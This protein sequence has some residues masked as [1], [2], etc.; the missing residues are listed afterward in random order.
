MQSYKSISNDQNNNEIK[1]KI[2]FGLV[3][4]VRF[5]GDGFS[6]FIYF[7]GIHIFSRTFIRGVPSYR[8]LFF[9]KK[10]TPIQRTYRLVKDV[11]YFKR[12]EYKRIFVLF[13]N[14]GETRLALEHLKGKISDTC[15]IVYTKRYH[16]QLLEMILPDIDNMFYPEYFSVHLSNK[17]KEEYFIGNCRISLLGLI[18]YFKNYERLIQLSTDGC[19]RHFYFNYVSSILREKQ[20]INI[21]PLILQKES[22]NSAREKLNFLIG[23]NKFVII[24]NETFSNQNLSPEFYQELCRML[25]QQG[26]K[27][28]FN[29]TGINKSNSLGISSFLSIQELLEIASHAEFVIGIRSGILDVLASNCSHIVAIYTAFK[30]RPGFDSLSAEKVL[31]AFSLKKIP[32][33]NTPRIDEV[34]ISNNECI[35]QS[36]DKIFGALYG[37]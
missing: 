11:R 15:L 17:A 31:E 16:K 3:K 1:H 4:Y 14:L 24:C 36:L 13:N 8:F 22:I 19:V 33:Q 37:K 23:K 5:Y 34:I 2:A 32:F 29:S 6:Y 7:L 20:V 27:I 26:Y 9:Q 18:S 25:Y 10:L 12:K 21:P 30:I 28:L 35:S